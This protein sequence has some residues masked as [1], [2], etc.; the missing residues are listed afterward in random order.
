M[1]EAGDGIRITTLP[2]S[3]AS[4]RRLR[5]FRNRAY[6][7]AVRCVERK[8]HRS[9]GV[10]RHRTHGSHARCKDVARSAREL[11]HSKGAA[12]IR[13]HVRAYRR[14]A[15]RH[16]LGTSLRFLPNDFLWPAPTAG[17]SIGRFVRRSDPW[18]GAAERE[19]GVSVSIPPRWWYRAVAR[20]AT[21]LSI[22]GAL[23]AVSTTPAA[24]NAAASNGRP[25]CVGNSTAFRSVRLARSGIP[26]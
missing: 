26:A 5:R 18:Y 2:F 8:T 20:I 6:A 9:D 7:A 23:L 21:E 11:F 13:E 19:M 3:S 16:W 24:R 17:S 15:G 1:L 4:T 12:G 25:P 10:E 22:D 14:R